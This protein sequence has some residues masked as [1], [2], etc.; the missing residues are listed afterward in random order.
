TFSF[1]R[2]F[3]AQKI[4]RSSSRQKKPY[5]RSQKHDITQYK[6]NYKTREGI[7]YKQN[8]LTPGKLIKPKKHE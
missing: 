1:K 2:R 7:M 4:I 3:I 6:T 8:R 5:K